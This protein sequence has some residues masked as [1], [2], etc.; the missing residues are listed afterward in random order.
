MKSL[1]VVLIGLSTIFVSS[2]FYSKESKTE[3]IEYIYH[4]SLIG[5]QNRGD[6]KIANDMAIR[7]YF[8]QV[9]HFDEPSET[10]E[11]VSTLDVNE[12]DFVQSTKKRNYEVMGFKK[13]VIE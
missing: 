7:P 13:F 8:N 10:F 3:H 1:V 6:A 5:V 11:I 4:F 2:S 12:S 9:A